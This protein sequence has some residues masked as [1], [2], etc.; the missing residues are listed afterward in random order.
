MP[1]VQIDGLTYSLDTHYREAK[2]ALRCSPTLARVPVCL[3][4]PGAGVSVPSGQF[5]LPWSPQACALHDVLLR[6]D[7]ASQLFG[8]CGDCDLTEELLLADGEHLVELS[9]R[10]GGWYLAHEVLAAL[11]ALPDDAGGEV[12]SA[13]LAPL[14]WTP[15]RFWPETL[16]RAGA[17]DTLLHEEQHHD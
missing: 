11:S 12:V 1:W 4:D 5:L 9:D 6:L 8:L 2:Q 3:G 15:A 10:P 14:A 17:W 16:A 7:V 13:A